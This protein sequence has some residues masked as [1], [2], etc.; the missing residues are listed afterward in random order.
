MLLFENAG[1]KTN[2]LKRKREKVFDIKTDSWV[3]RQSVL[4][5]PY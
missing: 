4:V 5:G 1:Q 2:F 3:A